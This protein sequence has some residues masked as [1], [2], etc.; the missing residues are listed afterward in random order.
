MNGDQNQINRG[1]TI[2]VLE[3][4]FLAPREFAD[5]WCLAPDSVRHLHA[6]YTR[7]DPDDEFIGDEQFI[8]H[9][10]QVCA[11]L[12]ELIEDLLS[13]ENSKTARYG[14]LLFERIG[15]IRMSVE[16]IVRAEFDLA[17]S[18]AK[19]QPSGSSYWRQNGRGT[20]FCQ[21]RENAFNVRER[22]GLA[23]IRQE[24]N[25]EARTAT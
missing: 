13:M 21:W 4:D 19:L 11:Y 8:I 18:L 20:E 15:S 23:V 2:N 10:G 17:A 1:L 5:G 22:A 24:V 12:Q 16:G 7:P 6:W 3:L 25:A 9:P 14:R